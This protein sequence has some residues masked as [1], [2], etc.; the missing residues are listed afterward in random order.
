MKLKEVKTLLNALGITY[1]ILDNN[2]DNHIKLFIMNSSNTIS[3]YE[4]SEHGWLT[5]DSGIILS[6]FYKYLFDYIYCDQDSKGNRIH[7]VINDSARDLDDDWMIDDNLRLK[8]VCKSDILGILKKLHIRYHAYTHF[9]FSFIRFKGIDGR[10]YI[11][12]CGFCPSQFI[13]IRKCLF[14]KI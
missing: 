13:S 10:D 4:Y 3:V 11:I 12:K 2:D 9:K 14:N 8:Y 6:N 5:K 7:R 1:L